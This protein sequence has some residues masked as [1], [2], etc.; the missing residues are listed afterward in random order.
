MATS[1]AVSVID[2]NEQFELG[3]EWAGGYVGGGPLHF[4]DSPSPL[5]LGLGFGDW[6]LGL[7]NIPNMRNIEEYSMT[8][9]HKNWTSK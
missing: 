1:W 6:G 7:V 2:E 5:E 4:S 8:A 9:P 3:V